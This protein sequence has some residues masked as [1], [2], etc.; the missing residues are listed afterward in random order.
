M[1][2]G[3]T[4]ADDPKLAM[5]APGSQSVLPVVDTVN[6]LPMPRWS[7]EA[8]GVPD[9]LPVNYPIQSWEVPP[10]TDDGFRPS[11]KG[12]NESGAGWKQT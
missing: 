5:T 6:V 10:P 3:N 1:Q 8:A 2:A 9:P 11:W 4:V 12:T 7:N